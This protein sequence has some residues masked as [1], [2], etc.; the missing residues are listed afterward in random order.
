[1]NQ[2]RRTCLALVAGLS[3][4]GFAAAQ[5]DHGTKEE[6]KA[7]VEAALSHVKKVGADKAFEDFTTNKGDWTKKD[8]Y[9]AMVDLEGVVRAHGAN[10]KLVGKNILGLK[11]Q[12]GNAFVKEMID[13][14]G[15]KGEGWVEYDWPNPVTQKVEA[16]ASYVQ[17]VAGANYFALV[18]V[19]R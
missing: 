7:M 3:F 4:S 11:D 6:A 2:L 17:R 8:L 13:I 10:Q 18:G 16:K 1:M 14:A 5:A 12:K 19:Y 15:K 9:V